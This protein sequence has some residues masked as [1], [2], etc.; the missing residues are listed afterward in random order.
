MTL[1][2]AD[3]YQKDLLV[4]IKNFKKNTKPGN[5]EKIQE[6]EIVLKNL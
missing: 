4:D 5:L 3:E 1:E 2:K 6:K